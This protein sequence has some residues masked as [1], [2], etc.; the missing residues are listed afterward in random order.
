[1]QPE[2][3]PSEYIGYYAKE[4]T[5][6]SKQVSMIRYLSIVTEKRITDLDVQWIEYIQNPD[7]VRHDLMSFANRPETRHMAPLTIRNYISA[8][9]SYLSDCCGISLTT[10]QKLMRKRNRAEKIRVISHEAEPTREMIRT[11]LA[12]CDE[13]TTAEVLIIIS[14]GL[15][16]HEVVNLRHEDVKLD[17]S[18]VPVVIRAENAKNGLERMT[19]I[20]QEAVEALKAYYRVREL[21]IKRAAAKTAHTSPS[22]VYDEDK[23][24][25]FST[26]GER[27]KLNTAIKKAG[28]DQR[29]PRTH[30]FMVH[31]HLYRKMFLTEGKRVAAPEYVEAWAGHT[32]YLSESY[33]RPTADQ[34]VKEYLK[35]E[36][37]LTVNVPE[38]YEKIKVEQAS[39][40]ATLQ[41]T[42]THLLA[43][44]TALQAAVE[45]MQK[46]QERITIAQISGFPRRL[47]HDD[48]DIS[49]V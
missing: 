40:I 31:F 44:L 15:R 20:S 4:R 26:Q 24:F 32:G 17:Q 30:R 36:A 2:M 23:I 38:D 25:P 49:D 6:H 22:F 10:L 29:D 16:I 5:R 8:V 11:I 7:Q 21:H 35:A 46:E 41:Q 12:H 13:R 14:G 39:E 37:A 28:F 42:N 9:E 3:I 45:D 43:Q 47:P 48:P 1:M 33:H 27:T 19:Y 34:Q 18:P